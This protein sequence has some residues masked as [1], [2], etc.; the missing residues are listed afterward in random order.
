MLQLQNYS[1][2][3]LIYDSNAY[4]VTSTYYLGTSTLQM[5]AIYLRP[6]V[7][8][9]GEPQYYITQLG[10]YAM[11]YALDTFRN[12]ALVYRNARD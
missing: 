8:P 2:P 3:T 7:A 4:T 10:A 5:Y 6:S 9:T 11:T 12:S 1:Q